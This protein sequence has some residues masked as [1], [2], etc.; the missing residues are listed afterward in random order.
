L[1]RFEGIRKLLQS[2]RRRASSGELSGFGVRLGMRTH[3]LQEDLV[4]R[5]AAYASASEDSESDREVFEDESESEGPSEQSDSP[6]LRGLAKL[7]NEGG[8]PRTRSPLKFNRSR[9]EGNMVRDS[10]TQLL[11]KLP[12]TNTIRRSKSPE[13][14]SS[15]SS[16]ERPL[17]AISNLAALASMHA[18][19]AGESR[20]RPERRPS[21][22]KFS[23]KPVP[24]A[25]VALDESMGPSIMFTESSGSPGGRIHQSIY[26][27]NLS[28]D[29]NR[30]TGFPFPQSVP[31]SFNDLPCRAQHLILND[32]MR[33]HS[34]HTAVLFTTLPS[35]VEGTCQ[36][37]DDSLSYITD[38]E[39]LCEGLPPVLLV[40]S[41][42]MTVTT[43]L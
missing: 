37:L 11:Q 32:L 35:P 5:H 33:Q 4:R 34:E 43:N 42:S 15:T 18:N 23:S 41:N 8:N 13:S 22:R 28:S 6:M 29:F 1:E 24:E 25:R 3:R 40:H 30:A 27:R 31:L 26:Q 38:L 20:P 39:V 12:D 14:L 7:H 17:T 10:T 16:V 9:S 36:S 2:P 21:A 19:Q